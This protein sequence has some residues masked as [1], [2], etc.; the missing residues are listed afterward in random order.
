MSPFTPLLKLA[1][2][3]PKPKREPWKR[4]PAQ[5][6]DYMRKYMRKYRAKK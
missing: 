6:R 1:G 5:W 2:N 3:L 4:D